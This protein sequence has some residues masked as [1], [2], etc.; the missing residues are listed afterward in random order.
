[1]NVSKFNAD[2]YIFSTDPLVEIEKPLINHIVIIDNY[3]L[4]DKIKPIIQSYPNMIKSYAHSININNFKLGY[5]YPNYNI[6]D[7]SINNMYSEFGK[8]IFNKDKNIDENLNHLENIVNMCNNINNNVKSTEIIIFTNTTKVLNDTTKNK[9]N[10]FVKNGLD[11]VFLNIGNLNYIFNGV[12]EKVIQLS[13]VENNMNYNDFFTN[14]IENKILL[15]THAGTIPDAT[16]NFNGNDDVYVLGYNNVVSIHSRKKNYYIIKTKADKLK[17]YIKCN[18]KLFEKELVLPEQ[19]KFENKELLLAIDNIVNNMCISNNDLLHHTDNY[20]FIKDLLTEFMNSNGENRYFSINIYTRLKSQMSKIK[21]KSIN[22]L[23][24]KYSTPIGKLVVSYIEKSKL[25]MKNSRHQKITDERIIKNKKLLEEL[26]NIYELVQN[27]KFTNYFEKHDNL[28][29]DKFLKS[30]E[31]FNSIISFS[32]W[33]EEV[34]ICGAMGLLIKVSSSSLTK[35]GVTINANIENITTT[36]FPIIDFISHTTEYFNENG[37]NFGNLNNKNIIKGNA[38]GNSNTVI[39]LFITKEHWSFAEK[40]LKI[41]LGLTLSHHPLGYHKNH[42]TFMFSILVNMTNNSFTNQTK[43]SERWLQC[44]FSLFRTCAEIAF[45]EK[46]NYGIRTLVNN[47]VNNPN[48]RINFNKNYLDNIIG[49]ILCTGYIINEDK[50]KKFIKCISEELIRNLIN[51]L[52]ELNKPS[53]INS[54]DEMLITINNIF[55]ENNVFNS[56]MSY[57]NMNNILK[58]IY[59]SYGSYSKFIKTLDKNYGLLSDLSSNHILEK[60]KLI[61]NKKPTSFKEMYEFMNINYNENELRLWIIQGYNH[62]KNKNRKNAIIKETY[63]NSFNTNVDENYIK[64]LLI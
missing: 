21:N 29:D 54:V 42:I 12:N 6:K 15:S 28:T 7:I 19:I 58:I 49:Q 62:K 59:N 48:K 23:I 10:N 56:L 3:L 11:L 51:Q 17:F 55:E 40:Y 8:I 35:L 9:I 41:I 46:Y 47:F 61:Q 5:T 38:I 18:E 32:N 1:M 26:N 52:K 45:K 20:N 27:N 13:T 31:F 22:D 39:P 4:G 34:K 33:Y 30:C 36:F 43:I 14:I 60:I 37:G 16:I 50:Q 64:S 53:D 57:F 63:I 24:D 44:Y 25:V 2:S